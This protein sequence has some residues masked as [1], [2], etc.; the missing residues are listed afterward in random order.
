MDKDL[1]DAFE[2]M[3]EYSEM[4]KMF[5]D[6]PCAHCHRKS[7]GIRPSYGKTCVDWLKWF[8]REWRRIKEMFA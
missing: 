8:G 7:C 5:P 3:E 6:Y 1:L 4:Q 2:R